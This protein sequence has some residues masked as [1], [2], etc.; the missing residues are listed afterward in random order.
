LNIFIK[1]LLNLNFNIIC[2]LD[3][4]IGRE[5]FVTVCVGFVYYF[6]GT[7]STLIP[8]ISKK[9]KSTL[10]SPTYCFGLGI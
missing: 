2:T 10:V 4:A 7:G 1:I 5:T 9:S 3:S 6:L 8:I